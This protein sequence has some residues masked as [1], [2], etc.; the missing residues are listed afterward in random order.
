MSRTNTN[1]VKIVVRNAKEPA[2]KPITIP[3]GGTLQLVGDGIDVRSEQTLTETCIYI[4]DPARKNGGARTLNSRSFLDITAPVLDVLNSQKGKEA[5]TSNLS[6]SE[7]IA[8]LS[9]RLQA[10]E[11]QPPV[12]DMLGTIVSQLKEDE[13]F[14]ASVLSDAIDSGALA[15]QIA[16]SRDFVKSV[17][18]KAVTPQAVKE[19][20]NELLASNPEL[21]MP[22]RDQV[23]ESVLNNSGLMDSITSKL[24][25][26]ASPDKLKT[27]V[28][29]A[30]TSA[31]NVQSIADL[32]AKS[33]EVSSKLPGREEVV[34]SILE[35]ERLVK[36]ISDSIP[37]A[38]VIA[39]MVTSSKLMPTNEAVV[40][41][42]IDDGTLAGLID[43]K[44][45]KNNELVK[46]VLESSELKDVVAQATPTQDDIVR[47]VLSSN[48]LK[49]LLPS[50]D[51]VIKSVLESD[52]L[53]S[54]LPVQSE[55]ISGVLQSQQLADLVSSSIP[56]QDSILSSL[57]S[58]PELANIVSSAVPVEEMSSSIRDSLVQRLPT[59]EQV[60]SS[61]AVKS[62][63][64]E[65]MPTNASIVSN[66]L[67]DEQ[68]AS[69][70]GDVVLD[71]LESQEFKDAV[72][73]RLPT[74]KDL[75]DEIIANNRIQYAIKSYVP[76]IQ[77][78]ADSIIASENF[79]DLLNS[80]LMS[81]EYTN[82]IIDSLPPVEEIGDYVKDPVAESLVSNE[83][84]VEYLIS[85]LKDLL[86]KVIDIAKTVATSEELKSVVSQAVPT[87]ESLINSAQS[88]GM[89]LDRSEVESLIRSVSAEHIGTKLLDSV[90]QWQKESRYITHMKTTAS[91]SGEDSVPLIFAK[92]SFMNGN[93]CV[94][95]ND[96]PHINKP[97]IFILTVNGVVSNDDGS[98]MTLIIGDNEYPIPNQPGSQVTPISLTTPVEFDTLGP[99]NISLSSIGGGEICAHSGFGV[100]LCNIADCLWSGVG[101][102]LRDDFLCA[103]NGNTLGMWQIVN[104]ESGGSVAHV[105][106]QSVT[107][108]HAGVVE[109]IAGGDTTSL[110]SIVMGG[111]NNCI[112]I[113]ESNVMF[114]CLIMPSCKM[115]NSDI[116]IGFV[117]ENEKEGEYF[118]ISGPNNTL[119]TSSKRM[120]EPF[121][122]V[123][124]RWYLLRYE[125][126]GGMANFYVD[127]VLV[128]YGP[129]TPK[130]STCKP[131]ISVAKRANEPGHNSVMVDYWTLD[132]GRC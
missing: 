70:I 55:V 84:F 45:P 50:Q 121:V 113:N 25:E 4:S 32:V 13:E 29:D 101:V 114:S 111:V 104:S 34:D 106:S 24:G 33:E 79:K 69:L 94:V 61:E 15:N 16:A 17:V 75:V 124:D 12:E 128:D 92:S 48:E 131:Q 73:S 117:S 96:Q 14:R 1:H 22:I 71:E 46:S 38:Q 115:T 68:L 51:S 82:L 77:G 8:N 116:T 118:L 85:M 122:L 110:A 99:V 105:N 57:L 20:I 76:S 95:V 107:K 28:S 11:S 2:S 89:M 119:V 30:V 23:I 9:S 62:A 64:N 103:T 120:S 39:D 65:L 100:S 56:T 49:S 87:I 19:R 31:V 36:S 93:S 123:S 125:L 88:R 72:D 60:G 91:L 43:E 78:V 58:S 5:L 109:L 86:P 10:L 44:V 52:S 102:S 47:E 67:D 21:L 3:V 74:I 130:L 132:Y 129:Y 90:P 37:S 59:P 83:S 41:S 126:I 42:M 27:M 97:G 26:L 98:D 7:L 81:E 66:L 18:D 54:L 112:N 40:Q 80:I 53:K 127:S 35:D 108:N 63:I 6:Q